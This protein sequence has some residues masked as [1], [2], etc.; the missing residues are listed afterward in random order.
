MAEFCEGG[1]DQSGLR[2]TRSV[3][4][5]KPDNKRYCPIC[6]QIH[7]RGGEEFKPKGRRLSGRPGG[8]DFFDSPAVSIYN[9][10]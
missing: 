1:C 2:R 4:S 5:H 6:G 8:T 9:Y 10:V 7:L 3:I